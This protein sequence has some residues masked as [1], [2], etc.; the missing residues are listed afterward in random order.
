MNNPNIKV[1]EL[2]WYV[3]NIIQSDKKKAREIFK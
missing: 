1:S 2:L 3:N